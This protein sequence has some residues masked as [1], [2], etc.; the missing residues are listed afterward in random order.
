MNYLLHLL[1]SDPDPDCYVGNLMG[2][3]IKGPLE[4]RQQQFRPEVVR[5]LK[6]HRHIDSYAQRSCVFRR[7]YQR[8]DSS[9]GLYRGI[10]VDLFYDHF[11]ARHWNRFHPQSL[12]VFA[13]KIYLILENHPGLVPDFAAIVPRMQQHNWLV[14][15]SHVHTIERALNFIS[16]RA[17]A[18]DPLHG[19]ILELEGHYKDLEQD[20]LLFITQA[21]W[22]INAQRHTDTPPW[23]Q[24]NK[25]NIPDQDS[26]LI[27]RPSR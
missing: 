6:Q 14:A 18:R 10:M 20:C 15:Y 7:S 5:G 24:N 22:W 23:T 16:Q 26:M 2:D 19:A 27:P 4:A 17:K 9:F 3:F 21:Q 11:A 13:Q 8:L 12:S 1:F 25:V